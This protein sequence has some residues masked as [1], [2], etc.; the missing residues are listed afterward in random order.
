MLQTVATHFVY[1]D[2][3]LFKSSNGWKRLNT[4]VKVNSRHALSNNRQ[5]ENGIKQARTTDYPH[6]YLPMKDYLKSVMHLCLPSL[7]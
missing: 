3:C 7:K 6:K 4:L 5:Y 1:D 2:K